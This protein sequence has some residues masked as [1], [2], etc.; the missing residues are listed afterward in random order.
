MNAL[1]VGAVPEMFNARHHH[2]FVI[3]MSFLSAKLALQAMSQSS[4]SNADGRPS[5]ILWQVL[6]VLKLDSLGFPD[7]EK[8][9]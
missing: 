6:R 9:K 8:Q 1:R 7:W 3:A 5:R 4:D 2:H